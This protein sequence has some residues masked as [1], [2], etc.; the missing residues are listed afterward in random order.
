MNDGA[1]SDRLVSIQHPTG[2]TTTIEYLQST[3]YRDGS[4]DLL[5]PTLPQT[6]ETVASITHDSGN[7]TPETTE[8]TYGGGDF[9]FA[10]PF[11][12]QF[13]GFATTTVTRSGQA[14]SPSTLQPP[15]RR[16]LF[17]RDRRDTATTSRRSGQPY[18]SSSTMTQPRKPLSSARS[19]SWDRLSAGARSKL[20]RE[21]S[22]TTAEPLGY[23]GDGDHRGHR[24]GVTC[25]YSTQPGT[26]P[27][28]PSG[29][30]CRASTNGTFS[31]TGS[32]KR[33]SDF[34]YA[35]P[36]QAERS[37]ACWRARSSKTNPLPELRR[38]ATISTANHSAPRP[39]ATS[40]SKSSGRPRRP[41][42]TL[43]A[44]TM[45]MA[46]RPRCSTRG[47]RQRISSTTHTISTPLP[48]P[49]RSPRASMRNTTTPRQ[50]STKRVDENNREFRWTYDGLDRVTEEK[51][52]D[53]TTPG[54][55]V[56]KA[57]YT[58]TTT[59]T[60]ISVRKTDHLDASNLVDTYSY[61]DGFGRP[62][63]TRT[64]GES[65]GTY[66]VRNRAYDA[67]GLL[68]R[69]S[70]TRFR[71]QL[72]IRLGHHH[73]RPLLQPHVRS[74]EA[75]ARAR[76]CGGHKHPGIRSVEDDGNGRKRASE[77]PHH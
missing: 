22:R 16:H 49:M 10:G 51:Q 65:A 32:D 64:E 63:Q 17:R 69:Q 71:E 74:P 18:S 1:V 11:D 58:Y 35:L 48:R 50:S 61:V 29:A 40:P 70:S 59:S 19:V 73:Q 55:L 77:D 44:R 66:V 38:P 62:I 39:K 23:D 24:S 72:L 12:R 27:R 4:D 15:G 75:D 30:R 57:T 36:H 26:S 8:F 42:S 45:P 25:T 21:V 41:I 5:N 54:T 33:T 9:Y 68:A 67:R 47:T 2:G 7:S 56:T 3:E 76:H 46:F 13:G 34:T 31:D 6:L 28:R 14:T 53:Q 60:P 43:N 20:L 52:P 37:G